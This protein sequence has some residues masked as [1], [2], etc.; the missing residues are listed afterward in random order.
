MIGKEGTGL[1][2]RRQE[3]ITRRPASRRPAVA[4]STRSREKRRVASGPRPCHGLRL[5][6]DVRRRKED[7]YQKVL[8]GESLSLGRRR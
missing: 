5:A 6:R 2:R 4:A 8:V 3:F 1:L 7:Y